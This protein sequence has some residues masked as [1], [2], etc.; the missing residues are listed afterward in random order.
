MVV[1]GECAR[2]VPIS[3]PP[4]HDRTLLKLQYPSPEKARQHLKFKQDLDE[5]VLKPKNLVE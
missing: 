4:M 5:R 3:N 1:W 2:G